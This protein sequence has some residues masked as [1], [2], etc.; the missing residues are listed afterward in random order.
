[1]GIDPHPSSVEGI[2]LVPSVVLVPL[3]DTGHLNEVQ[4]G[5]NPSCG[6][7]RWVKLGHCCV[8]CVCWVAQ[9]ASASTRCFP[10]GPSKHGLVYAMFYTCASTPTQ[11]V[12]HICMS[13]LHPSN[14]ALCCTLHTATMPTT[15]CIP[16]EHALL[17]GTCQSINHACTCLSPIQQMG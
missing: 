8:W 15:H 16:R 7:I 17:A 1:M 6:C 3:L 4:D 13:P 10:S 5:R 2:H 12:G 11:G 14:Q 9:H